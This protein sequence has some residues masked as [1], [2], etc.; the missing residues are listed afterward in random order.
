MSFATNLEKAAVQKYPLVMLRPRRKITS[1]ESM[2]GVVYRSSFT[3][4]FIT[5][6]WIQY[7]VNLTEAASSAVA[8]GEFYYDHANGYLYVG[9]VVDPTAV[10]RFVE[11]EIH[12]STSYFRGPRDP[13]DTTSQVVDWL[14]YLAQEPAPQN[15][16]RDNLYGFNP[17]LQSALNI[18]NSNGWMNEH[19]HESSFRLALVKTWLMADSNYDRARLFSN[20]KQTFLGYAGDS[21]S[22]QD[23]IVSISCGDYF[24]ALDKQLSMTKFT[25]SLAPNCEPGACNSGA[26]WLVRRIRGRVEQMR[27]VNVDYD[28]TPA[29]NKN[30]DWVVMEEEATL[31]EATYTLVV[32]HL[33]ANTATKTFFTETP[34]VMAGDV[35]AMTNNGV[36]RYGTVTAVDYASK[37]FTHDDFSGRTVTA[38][39]TATRYFVG[40]I[41]IVREDGQIVRPMPSRDFV[42]GSGTLGTLPTGTRGFIFVD[43][44]EAN[45]SMATPLDPATDTIYITAYGPKE[46]QKYSDNTTDVGVV[47][48]YGGADSSP[49]SLVYWLLRAGGIDADLID[50]ASLQSAGSDN[51]KP[52]GLAIPRVHTQADAPTYK[53]LL[54]LVLQSAIWRLG[55]VASG[56]EVKV[57]VA[58]TQPFVAGADYDVDELDARAMAYEHDYAN[59]Y[60][61]VKTPHNRKDVLEENEEQAWA[62]AGVDLAEDLHLVNRTL[63]LESLHY[64][65]ADAAEMAQRLAYAVSDRR[66]IYRF[67]LEQR[68]IDKTN[69][70]ATYDLTREELPGYAQVVGTKRTRQIAA[71]EIVKSSLGATLVAEDQKGIQDNSGS[72]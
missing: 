70:G 44:F 32:D 23:R 64:V 45:V 58:P 52:L 60:S 27:P 16:S 8:G 12:L 54:Q 51:S 61:V 71:I 5:S 34:K 17:L 49:E 25:T 9:S 39:D 41:T 11:Y 59:I 14:P 53:E 18:H 56:N 66:G 6:C 38:G 47:T 57:G 24:G 21:L 46:L 28:A 26:E 67:E 13:L 62:T 15:G 3:L 22:L 10:G 72:W 19:L 42:R 35:F 48:D 4:G 50:E 55:F 20:I 37:W 43:N 30:R 7:G 1:W 36:T 65:Y 40:S 29:T 31:D 63:T 69:I 68:F 33:A 2:G